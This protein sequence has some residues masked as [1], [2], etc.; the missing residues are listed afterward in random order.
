MVALRGNTIQ[1]YQPTM[2]CRPQALRHTHPLWIVLLY[3]ALFCL[4]SINFAFLLSVFFTN[5]V[6]SASSA[7]SHSLAPCS[8]VTYSSPPTDTSG[9]QASSSRNAYCY[10]TTFSFGADILADFEL[11]EIGAVA[12]ELAAG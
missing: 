4:G 11:S 8:L 3:V 2:H 5:A 7:P 1:L 10:P 6:L 12:G 9:S